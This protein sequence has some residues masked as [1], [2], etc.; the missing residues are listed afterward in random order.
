MEEVGLKKL[1]G[2]GGQSNWKLPHIHT[3]TGVRTHLRIQ[4]QLGSW[5]LPSLRAPE[6]PALHLDLCREVTPVLGL[7]LLNFQNFAS[8][9][10]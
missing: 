6:R 7:E 3:A 1:L 8:K 2:C 5:L 10:C 9:V 4:L